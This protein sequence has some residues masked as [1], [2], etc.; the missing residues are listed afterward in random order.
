MVSTGLHNRS[1]LQGHHSTIGVSYKGLHIGQVAKV[2]AVVQ[3]KR[4]SLGLSLP[5]LS[6][7]EVSIGIVGSNTAQVGVVWAGVRLGGQMGSSCDLV[8]RV[9]GHNSTVG[10][11]H[12]ASISVSI[13]L[14][15]SEVVVASMEVWAGVRLGG[16]MG[17]SCDLVGRVEGHNSAVGVVHQASISV[18]ISLTLSEVVVASVV[19]WAGVRLGGQMGSSC[20]LVGR[21]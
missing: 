15:L 4:V 13:S 6:A 8:G 18:S 20:D 16:Q 2:V 11:G 5:P 19:V 10:V 14:T 21:V 3:H 7:M 9:E 12:Q 17:R 1:R